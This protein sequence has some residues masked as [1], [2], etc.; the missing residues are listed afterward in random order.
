MKNQISRDSFDLVQ[1]YSGVYLQQGRM[2][3]DADWNELSDIQKARLVDALRDAIAGGAPRT[4][5]LAVYADP[6]GSATI[7]IR[8]GTLYVEGVPARLDAA[9][10]LAVDAQPDYP[11]KA[12]YNGQ[13]LRLYADVWDRNVTALERSELLDA[14]LHG[15]DTATRTQTMLQVKW[16][17][18]TTD[19]LDPA[20]NPPLGDAPLTLRL[21]LIASS[22]DACD[23]CASQ[24]K[25]DERLGNYLFRVEVHDYDAASK[26]LTLKW[27]R[28]NGAEACAVAAMPTG[29]DQG[30]WVWEYF[31]T[32][33][34]RF[35]GN[36][37]AP[38][39][40]KLR[41]LI[42][43]TCTTPAGTDDPKTFVRQ[44]DGA[45]KI[46]LNTG[47]ILAA[48]GC[49]NRDRGVALFSDA[50]AKPDHGRVNLTG[51]VLRINLD[52]M[53]LG[54][55][56][57]GRHFVPGDYW[58]A[59]VRE[60]EHVS[61]QY[62]LPPMP[63]LSVP[64]QGEPPRGVRHHYLL[65]GELGIN[66]KLVAQDDAFRRRM[67][68][69]PLTDLTA[70]DVGF[71]DGCP[72]LFAGAKNVQQALDALC[73]IDASDIAYPLPNCGAN[74]GK[75]IKDRL[76]A[77]LDPDANN[78]LTVKAALDNLLCQLN[79]GSLPYAVPACAGTPS[80]RTLLGLAAGDNN[81][82]PVLDKLLC[83]FRANDLPLDKTDAGLCSDLQAAGVVT[84]QDA[85]KIL[86]GK[87]GGGCAV[88][89]TSS[90]HLEQL[91]KEFAAS[92]AT[93]LW[94]C[95]KAGSYPLPALPAIVGKRSLRLSGEGAESVAISFAGTTLAF[96]ADEVIL[97]NLALTFT[98]ANGQLAI[99]AAL[100]QAR[101]CRFSRTSDIPFNP[102]MLSV[103]GQGNAACRL[104]CR[105]SVLY[106]QVKTVSGN[107]NKWA[108]AT[109]VG[110]A[111]MSKA[112]LDLGQVAL[113]SDKAAYDAAVD[114]AATQLMALP[115]QTRTSWQANLAKLSAPR[116]GSK[117]VPTAGVAAMNEVL[118]QDVMNRAD[119]VTAI[120]NMVAQ[121]VEYASD[122][123]LRLETVKVGGV[124]AGNVID[125]WVLLANGVS[126]YRSPD[127]GI[128]GTKL[129]TAAVMPGGE[130]LRIEGNRIAAIKTNLVPASID[131]NHV[132]GKQ[133]AGYARL[134]LVGNSFAETKNSVVAA[135]FVGQ[136]NTWRR[137]AG[138]TTP[139][140]TVIADRATFSG[141][142]LEGSDVRADLTG[143][144]KAGFVASVGNV[145]V[146]LAPSI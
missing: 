35:L 87:S 93:D 32:D 131:T 135:H 41:G 20:V 86:C 130:E 140:G 79:A 92:A 144:A 97:E 44:W 108:S 65:L 134:F 126:D 4:G 24:V 77:T 3:L 55:T 119:A 64:A 33:T 138:D 137:A 37:F 120:E 60:A 69:P 83:D 114:A 34:E 39:P 71:T 101:G 95:L 2:I 66:K 18:N 67:A 136:G 115:P 1:R 112:I 56:T 10:P 106:A 118:A 17:A 113:L 53:E 124:L 90:G 27:S 127:T 80:V 30:D 96:G 14:A 28:D 50:V 72:G 25:V 38:N 57:T 123:A 85:L 73:G 58:V 139:T 105:D 52:L 6:A 109:M 21:R 61:G 82:A 91:L 19:P 8:P 117:R 98:K 40:K 88:V 12:D 74:D 76:K 9:A 103:S 49:P 15:A 62:V 31:D 42:K 128:V 70:A 16:C 102:A 23:P 43:P 142:L 145:L 110:D 121:W 89:A 48:G 29:F 51:G 133:A 36:H 84:V 54:L 141:N 7:R 100:A 47:N 143:T 129:T 59:E 104:D 68:F 45:V 11:I 75:S 81:V 63:D 46:D 132:L 94:V 116:A 125:G 13:S 99:Q 122:Y 5:G 22:G 111:A 78:Q 107:G 26:A 146:D